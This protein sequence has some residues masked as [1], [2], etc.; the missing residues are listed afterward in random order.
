MNRVRSLGPNWIRINVPALDQP[1]PSII[2]Q[3]NSFFQAYMAAAKQNL[4]NYVTESESKN[5]RR[6][7][8][9][10][11]NRFIRWLAEPPRLETRL[12]ET[13]PPEELDV[14]IGDFIFSLRNPK[15]GLYEPSTINQYHCSIARYKLRDQRLI[16]SGGASRSQW[17]KNI[18]TQQA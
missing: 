4:Q 1:R 3:Y 10:H 7:T 2:F 9:G 5:T 6:Q 13:I 8:K 12:P 18:T 14:Y 11:M 15:G 17:K 16:T